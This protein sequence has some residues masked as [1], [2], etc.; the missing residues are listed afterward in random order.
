[1]FRLYAG[2]QELAVS[3]ARRVRHS[4]NRSSTSPEP[5]QFRYFPNTRTFPV[6]LRRTTMSMSQPS[7]TSIRI[8]RADEKLSTWPHTA[9]ETCD[10][11]SRI[12]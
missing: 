9:I 1:M 6:P 10:V 12:R 3:P 11:A 5:S 7:P 8:K 2:Y 4:D